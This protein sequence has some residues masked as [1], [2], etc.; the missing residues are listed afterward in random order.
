V[1]EAARGRSGPS[2]GGTGS[3]QGEGHP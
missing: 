1:V 3:G 2:E